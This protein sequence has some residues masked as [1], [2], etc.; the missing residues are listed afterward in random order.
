[1]YGWLDI[2]ILGIQSVW[3]KYMYFSHIHVFLTYSSDSNKNTPE[4]HSDVI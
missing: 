2:F 4:K 3:E 1:M